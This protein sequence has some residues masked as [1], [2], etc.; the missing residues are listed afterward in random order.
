M[1]KVRKKNTVKQD[2]NYVPPIL[3][4]LVA[5]LVQY[6]NEDSAIR[7]VEDNGFAYQMYEVVETES[8]TPWYLA[9]TEN[10]GVVGVGISYYWVAKMADAW[11]EAMLAKLDEQTT[12]PQD[13]GGFAYETAQEQQE[14]SFDQVDEQ[15][16]P[17]KKKTIN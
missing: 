12:D 7:Y 16:M 17:Y 13:D 15:S 14:P 1:K 2:D 5:D 8:G 11:I 9:V 10:G 6:I 3:D 4:N